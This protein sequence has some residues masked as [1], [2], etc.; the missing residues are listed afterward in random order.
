MKCVSDDPRYVIYKITKELANA[1][2][3]ESI[4]D[5]TIEFPFLYSCPALFQ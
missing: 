5:A 2:K 1:E 3:G 4:K